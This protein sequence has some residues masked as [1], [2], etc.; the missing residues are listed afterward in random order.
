MEPKL[1][2]TQLFEKY[3][4]IMALRNAATNQQLWLKIDH[5]AKKAWAA[6]F[7][8]VNR[9]TIRNDIGSYSIAQGGIQV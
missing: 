5:E 2:T 8:A 6:W 4:S 9:S 7:F 1:N 3:E